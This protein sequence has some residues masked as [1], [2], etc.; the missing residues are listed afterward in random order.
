MTEAIAEAFGKCASAAASSTT[1]GP[2][3]NDFTA[4]VKVLWPILDNNVSLC[5][6]SGLF[7]ISSPSRADGALDIKLFTEFL[8]ALSK[9][10]YPIVKDPLERLLKEI[11]NAKSVHFGS[12]NALFSKLID[13]QVIRALLKFD[14]PL[15]RAFSA[16]AGDETMARVGGSL[17]W[18]DVKSQN[19]GMEIQGF[20]NFCSSYSLIPDRLSAQQCVLLTKDILQR[21][22][23]LVSEKNPNVL[24]YPQFQLLLALAAATISNVRNNRRPASSASPAVKVKAVSTTP[25]QDPKRLADNLSDLLKSIG[26]NFL[27]TEGSRDMYANS[28]G[29]NGELA[30]PPTEEEPGVPHAWSHVAIPKTDQPQDLYTALH[31]TGGETALLRLQHAFGDIARRLQMDRQHNEYTVPNSFSRTFTAMAL[32]AAP[33]SVGQLSAI[34]EPEEDPEDVFGPA[35]PPIQWTCDPSLAVEDDDS[36]FDSRAQLIVKPIVIG[37]AVPP[38]L[39][40]PMPVL[41]VCCKIVCS[42]LPY[43]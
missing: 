27:P 33:S 30:K 11:I 26:V 2:M 39:D 43:M 17:N 38:P 37:D 13:K 22:P 32:S 36:L 41:H 15:R 18:E 5:D 12:D 42:M 14:L 40:C 3:I 16:F 35:I 34:G 8:T 10:K 6:L 19:I 1:G 25:A 21:F 23:V 24:L 20:S 4:V 9:L 28:N 29:Q 7:T 31:R